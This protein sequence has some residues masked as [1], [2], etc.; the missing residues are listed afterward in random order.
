VD[1]TR[2]GG[3]AVITGAVAAGS[4]VVLDGLGMLLKNVRAN[5]EGGSIPDLFTPLLVDLWQKGDFPFD[6]LFGRAYAHRDIAEAIA[7]MESGQVIK[8]VVT[9][10]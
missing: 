1:C 2:V 6:R 5:V 3:T 9:Y 8:P 10:S 4:E 7:G